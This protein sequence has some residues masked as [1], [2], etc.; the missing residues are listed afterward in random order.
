MKLS[1]ILK[2]DAQWTWS[3]TLKDHWKDE[4]YNDP[5]TEN[6]NDGIPD[7]ERWEYDVR[8]NGKVVGSV[9]YDDF[10]GNVH[11]SFGERAPEISNYASSEEYD[12][13]DPERFILSAIQNY[14]NS[15][16]GKLHFEVLMRQKKIVPQ[17]IEKEELEE[18]KVTKTLAKK[19]TTPAKDLA[20]KTKM[21]RKK[22]D[23]S[24]KVK[25]DASTPMNRNVHD[26]ANI[27]LKGEYRS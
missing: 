13:D 17:S 18:I 19:R 14:F 4:S 23:K 11:V 7:I 20:T 21:T 25:K 15:K 27:T 8:L 10:F 1:E 16:T 24:G 6:D 3:L 12:S 2:E 26:L 5:W 22:K 9:E